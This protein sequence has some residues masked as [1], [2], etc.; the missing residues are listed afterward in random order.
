MA[1]KLKIPRAKKNASGGKSFIPR[2]PIVRAAL[3]VFIVLSIALSSAFAYFYVKYDRIIDEKFRGQVFANTAKIYSIPQ[4]VRVGEK[5]DVKEI[6]NQLRRA[7][8]S[9]SC[10]CAVDRIWRADFR[11]S[12]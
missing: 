9:R 12:R 10:Y 4:T 8:V 3:I 7:V 1:I 5:I 11:R 6:A 2:D